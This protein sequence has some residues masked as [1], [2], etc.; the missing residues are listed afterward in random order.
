MLLT[1]AQSVSSRAKIWSPR[2][3][4]TGDWEAGMTR[5]HISWQAGDAVLLVLNQ[6]R[7]VM[8]PDALA[9]GHPTH[10]ATRSLCDL[11]RIT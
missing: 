4:Y 6:R 10:I 5:S 8:T 9:E 11:G 1:R 7:P 3:A 2:P